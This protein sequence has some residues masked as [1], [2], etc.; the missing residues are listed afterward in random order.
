MRVLA[1][2]ITLAIS[3]AFAI[4]I[5]DDLSGPRNIGNSILTP[6]EAP[7]E[8]RVPQKLTHHIYEGYGIHFS[9]SL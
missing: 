3:N 1:I 6:Y 4:P 7:G 8:V 9:P 5:V 2:F